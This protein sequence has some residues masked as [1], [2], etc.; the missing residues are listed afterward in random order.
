MLF[1]IVTLLTALSMAAVAAWFA[2]AGIMAVF[3]GA[4][5]PALI[6]GA[7]IETGKVVGVSWLYQNLKTKTTIKYLLA[8]L[9]VT[10]MLLTS[11]GIFGFLSKAHLEQTTPVGNNAA[12]IERLDQRIARQQKAID[13]AEGVIM[14]LDETVQVLINY[15][16]ISGPDGARAVRA[17]QQEQRDQLAAIIDQSE[18]QIAIFQDQR[19]ELAAEI[20]E[21]ELE[22]GPVKY[23]AALVYGNEEA[24]DLEAAVRWVII[25]FIFVFDPMAIVLLMAANHTLMQHKKPRP[26][27]PGIPDQDIADEDIDLIDLIDDSP[28]EDE[29][30]DEDRHSEEPETVNELNNVDNQQVEPETRHE[31]HAAPAGK[32][33]DPEVVKRLQ[34]L[35]RITRPLTDQEI[36]QRSAL[37][38]YVNRRAIEEDIR[39]ERRNNPED[40]LP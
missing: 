4:P 8:P 24:T 10:A 31:V 13:D 12:Q 39:A 36:R 21:L 32:R 15:D 22:V 3:A 30:E 35:E 29:D 37:R 16:K 40:N 6:M 7:V 23:I 34:S 18:D 5:L 17:G 11:M 1:G 38:D 33:L 20:R 2:I 27:T 25:A 19:F 28:H 26:V 14:Q 9:V